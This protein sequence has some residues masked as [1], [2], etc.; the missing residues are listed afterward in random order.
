MSRLQIVA[1]CAVVIVI[2]MAGR[3]LLNRGKQG[4]SGG[5]GQGGAGFRAA[6][7]GQQVAGR[8]QGSR[9]GVAA[10]TGG[11][12][13]GARPT[14]SVD[15]INRWY[16]DAREQIAMMEQ[17]ELVRRERS[18]NALTDMEKLVASETFLEERFGPKARRGFT[19]QERLEIGKTA[20]LTRPETNASS[21][22]IE[23]AGSQGQ[24]PP[25]E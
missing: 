10:G 8:P 19:R 2:W 23:A 25:T 12:G 20:R 24:T 7:R 17:D 15:E 5:R 6:G 14:A 3:W 4:G 18:W 21:E 16:Q 11:R 13:P 22:S 1:I 9:D